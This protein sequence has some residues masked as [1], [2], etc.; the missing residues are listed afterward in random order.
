LYLQRQ[1]L[2]LLLLLLLLAAAADTAVTFHPTLL[3]TTNTMT[4]PQDK[5]HIS[6]SL[7]MLALLKTLLTDPRNY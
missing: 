1:L 4:N 3:T 7:I 2:L 6:K 5:E